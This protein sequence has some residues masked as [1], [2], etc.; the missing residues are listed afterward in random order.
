MSEV[1]EAINQEDGVIDK[2]K[3]K[4]SFDEG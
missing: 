1:K 3:M 2:L 4:K